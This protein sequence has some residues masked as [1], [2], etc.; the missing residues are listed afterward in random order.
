MGYGRTEWEYNQKHKPLW[1]IVR[2]DNDWNEGGSSMVNW[3]YNFENVS[4]NPPTKDYYRFLLG[5]IRE[6]DA[7]LSDDE[8]CTAIQVENNDLNKVMSA[9]I[10]LAINT[11]SSALAGEVTEYALGPA[12]EKRGHAEARLKRLKSLALSYGEG[13]S[14]GYAFGEK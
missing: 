7:L 14:A 5:D 13:Y 6:E 11:L 2:R 9:L 4:K 10:N 1:G 3:N 12:K 8:I